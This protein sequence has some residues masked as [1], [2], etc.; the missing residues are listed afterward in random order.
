PGVLASYPDVVAGRFSGRDLTPGAE[1]HHA[2]SG[3]GTPEWAMTGASVDSMA[4]AVTRAALSIAAHPGG[5]GRDHRGRRSWRGLRLGDATEL[6][7]RAGGAGLGAGR[8]RHISLAVRK[9]RKRAY[10]PPWISQQS[11]A[12]F[13]RLV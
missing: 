8:L 7:R 6:Q 9:T 10:G 1:S 2:F 11:S 13:Y 5:Q 12:T 4:E 3:S